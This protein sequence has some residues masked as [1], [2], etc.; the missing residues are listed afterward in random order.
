MTSSPT[1][2]HFRRMLDAA[3]GEVG[4]VQQAVDA[5]QVDERAVVGDVLDDALDDRAF[6]QR[7]QELLALLAEARFEHGAARHD[8][9]VALAVELDDL[10]LER[11]VLVRRGVL[12]RTDVD[13]RAGQERADAVDHHGEA[14]LHLAGDE[15]GDD[16]A[17]LHRGFEV[18][19]GLEA[20]G[21]VARELGLAV[22]VFEA[23]DRD[24]DEIAG[25]DL[26]LALVVL[27][28]LDRD[29]A[30]GLESGVDD[31]DVVV[32]ADDFGGDE[33][34]LAHL[35]A[36]EGFLEQRGEVFDR[37]G[38]LDAMLGVAVAMAGWFLLMSINRR[39]RE[40][41]FSRGGLVVESARRAPAKALCGRPACTRRG[42]VRRAVPQLAA[43]ALRSPPPARGTGRARSR[44]RRRS[45]CRVVSRI[46]ASAAGAERGYRPA[47]VARVALPDIAQKT[48]NCTGDSFFDQLLMPPAAPA[49]PGSPSGTP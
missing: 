19:P 1:D 28:F 27:E 20:L 34:A 4:D 3:P 24:G 16:G 18:V 2:E 12:D 47:G 22:A 31:D 39:E 26:D 43:L 37:G 44:S 30:F 32:D 45:S 15:A 7:R 21:L 41:C 46:T 11:L 8:D 10:E 17:L 40:P 48:F 23:L 36:R 14:A 9:V 33:L 49:P 42:T 25:L 29:E 13:E 6:L 35:L 38:V 5:A